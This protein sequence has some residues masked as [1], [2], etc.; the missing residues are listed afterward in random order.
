VSHSRKGKG[1]SWE[2][3]V[4]HTLAA[5]RRQQE[6][7]RRRQLNERIDELRRRE[8][9]RSWEQTPPWMV[10]EAQRWLSQDERLALPSKESRPT[11]SRARRAQKEA[12]SSAK[13]GKGTGGQKAQAHRS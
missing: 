7:E 10:E 11:S 3:H 8:G 4:M 12:A 1:E 13:P 9:L 5:D 6:P 2:N